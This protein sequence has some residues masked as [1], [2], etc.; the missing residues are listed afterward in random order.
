MASQPSWY[1]HKAPALTISQVQG[2]LCQVLPA[3]TGDARA[4]LDLVAS[5]QR[6]MHAASLSPRKRRGARLMPRA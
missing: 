4:V 5:C 3:R 2:L 6:R 1:T